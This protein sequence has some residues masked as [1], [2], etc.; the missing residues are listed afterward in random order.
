M[1]ADK[2]P[3][4]E[5]RT[6]H[7]KEDPNDL[8][9]K[10]TQG[11]LDRRHQECA[12]GTRRTTQEHVSRSRPEHSARDSP[13]LDEDELNGRPCFTREIRET[14]GPRKFKLMAET[15]K[16]DG[17]QEP[18]AWLDDYLTAVRFQ[19]GDKVMAMQYIQL[20]LTGAARN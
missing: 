9:S 2:P 15:P 4:K 18:R 13:E 1:G 19:R 11:K 17:L 12:E 5:N 6:T 7:H 10:I 14:R 8:R 20:Q 3:L 16:Y